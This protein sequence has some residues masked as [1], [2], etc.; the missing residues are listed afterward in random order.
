VHVWGGQTLINM[1]VL[2]LG[3]LFSEFTCCVEF[4]MV[5][6]LGG[7]EFF[8]LKPSEFVIAKES[9]WANCYDICVGQVKMLYLCYIYVIFMSCMS[10]MPYQKIT[11]A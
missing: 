5:V 6:F 2:S 4:Q 9:M 10:K 11:I 3:Y 8:L 7:W 1:G